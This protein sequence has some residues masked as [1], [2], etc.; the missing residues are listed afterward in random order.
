M[1]WFRTIDVPRHELAPRRLR[2]LTA[3][4]DIIKPLKLRG[5]KLQEAEERIFNAKQPKAEA[6]RLV[7]YH[8]REKSKR[9]TPLET[10]VDLSDAQELRV[11]LIRKLGC[12]YRSDPQAMLLG[13]IELK[14][15]DGTMTKASF[16]KLTAAA[17]KMEIRD[18]DRKQRKSEAKWIRGDLE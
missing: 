6:K 18:V 16:Q 3:A 13:K 7:K 2:T 10:E 9:N 4:L 1:R 17:L 5:K 12:L 11:K 8:E 14:I 15:A